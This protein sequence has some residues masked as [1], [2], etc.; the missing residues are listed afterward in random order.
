MK[1]Y[2]CLCMLFLL[3]SACRQSAEEGKLPII[4]FTAFD[5][6]KPIH[7]EDEITSIEYIPLETTD[8]SLIGTVGDLVLTDDY[9]F[10]YSYKTDGI[11]QFDRKGRFV[12][13][14]ATTGNGPGETSQIVNISADEENRVLYVSQYFS[15][16]MYSFDGTFI[17]KLDILRPYSFQ[18]ALGDHVVAEIGRDF[19]PLTLP[20]MFGLGV[21]NLATHDTVAM[22]NDFGDLKLLSPEE[23]ALKNIKCNYGIDRS[24]LVSIDG[25][26]TLYRMT[27]T[28]ILPAYTIRTGY[29][30]AVRTGLM[31][32]A[33]GAELY[34]NMCSVFDLFETN[35]FCIIRT[36]YNDQF[37]IFCIDKETG[38][39]TCEQVSFDFNDYFGYNRLLTAC[40]LK[41]KID[42]G[43]P[44]WPFRSYP[45][46]KLLV[47]CNMG[48]EI[49]HLLENDK[50]IKVDPAWKNVTEESNPLIILYHL[51]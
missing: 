47:Q 31:S 37:R 39:Q 2:Y 21:F 49:A 36:M 17:K 19:V 23:T 26:D 6:K 1:K 9:L 3:L 46:K 44:I 4:D 13:N 25:K 33:L 34:D 29:T 5:D 50:S 30:D 51:K 40:G 38:E 7:L 8:E 22:K 18:F 32:A 14:F 43:L 41:N 24:V 16:F 27:K 20:G 35:R 15:T 11:M 42:G 12:R 10:I 45:D 48:G 28:G